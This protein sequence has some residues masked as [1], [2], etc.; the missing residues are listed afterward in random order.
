MQGLEQKN[1]QLETEL[2]HKKTLLSDAQI[3]AQMFERSVGITAD[4][5][6][7]YLVKQANDRCTA[8]VDIMQQQI[9]S[10]RGQLEERSREVKTISTRYTELQRSRDAMLVEKSETINQLS[11]SVEDSQRHCQMLMAKNDGQTEARLQGRI[12]ELTDQVDVMQKTIGQL[13]MRLVYIRCQRT[14]FNLL[15][16]WIWDPLSLKIRF[17]NIKL[18]LNSVNLTNLSIYW[19]YLI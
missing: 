2:E 13:E 12:H 7:D 8:Q 11:R 15:A 1:T 4:R 14:H 19:F 6:V 9:E 17:F 16:V 18:E 10:L 5:N 3:K